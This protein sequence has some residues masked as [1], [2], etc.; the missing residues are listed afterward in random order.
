MRFVPTAVKC[1]LAVWPTFESMMARGV[2][3]T[4]PHPASP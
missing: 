2:S 3:P 4:P 1:D